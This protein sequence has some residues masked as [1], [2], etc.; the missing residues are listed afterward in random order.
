MSE[1]NEGLADRLEEIPPSGM[2]T[3]EEADQ[4][5]AD[6]K[7]AA[8]ALRSTGG[9]PVDAKA[10]LRRFEEAVIEIVRDPRHRATQ[11]YTD[12]ENDLLDALAHPVET[13]PA[14]TTIPTTVLESVAGILE[15]PETSRDTATQMASVLRD[16]LPTEGLAD[17]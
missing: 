12:C 10:L 6:L 7:E 2:L 1:E 13:E 16:Y 3:I 15:S 5:S 4:A 9:K 8:T 14:K 11:R 17:E